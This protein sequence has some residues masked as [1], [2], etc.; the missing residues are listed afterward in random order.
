MRAAIAAVRRQ[1]PREIVVAVPIGAA[2]TCTELDLLV[3]AVVCPCTPADF[4]AVGQG[5]DDFS[6]TTDEEVRRLLA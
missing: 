3:D 5:Y 4:R 1:Q 2:S 6:Q